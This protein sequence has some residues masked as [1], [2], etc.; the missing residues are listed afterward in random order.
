MEGSRSAKIF[1]YNHSNYISESEGI[2]ISGGYE[3]N[4]ALSKKVS[5]TYVKPYSDCE[6]K[7]NIKLIPSSDSQI[8]DLFVQSP[9]T[10][11]SADC[12]TYCY[13]ELILNKCNCIDYSSLFLNLKN[14]QIPKLCNW[15]DAS[16]DSA[17]LADLFETTD[18]D[19]VC[20]KKCPYE[21][22]QVK[23]SF[24][25]SFSVLFT[26]SQTLKVNVYFNE[27]SYEYSSESPAI[28]EIALFGGLGGTLGKV[29]FVS[30]S[31]I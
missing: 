15:D 2:D 18:F 9:Y 5:E 11:R 28:S 27:L 25:T 22:D 23:L 8:F 16:N 30:S 24:S 12:H 10:Y 29:V 14:I 17:C 20:G 13:Q 31:L 3:T 21:C 26:D 4:I 6:I 1:I 7:N 19:A